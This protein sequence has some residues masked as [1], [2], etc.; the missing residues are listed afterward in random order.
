MTLRSVAMRDLVSISLDP[1]D[2]AAVE[3]ASRVLRATLPV[4]DKV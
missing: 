1:A 2:R 4:E 3:S